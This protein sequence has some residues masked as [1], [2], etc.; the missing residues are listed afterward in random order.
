[1]TLFQVSPKVVLFY[2]LS[3]FVLSGC[4]SSDSTN[5]NSK[6][7]TGITDNEDTSGYVRL[8]RNKATEKSDETKSKSKPSDKTVASKKTDTAKTTDMGIDNTEPSVIAKRKATT[9]ETNTETITVK[10]TNSSRRQPGTV[11]DLALMWCV[12]AEEEDPDIHDDQRQEKDSLHRHDCVHH[13]DIRGLNLMVF[14]QFHCGQNKGKGLLD[15]YAYSVSA[16]GVIELNLY[17]I[18]IKRYDNEG[19]IELV[20]LKPSKFFLTRWAIQRDPLFA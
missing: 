4:G 12:A 17:N 7:D 2:V 13:Q 6:T 1:M 3:V 5:N 14:Q 8:S 11:K 18:A 19:Y 15:E 10:G 9:A 20:K 16:D